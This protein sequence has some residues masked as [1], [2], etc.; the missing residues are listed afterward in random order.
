MK[1]ACIIRAYH[2][3]K[4]LALLLS[5]LRHP[6]VRVYLHIDRRKP[7]AP[8]T[9][10]LAEAGLRDIVLLPRYKSW[11]GSA[12]VVDAGLEGLAAGVADG[13]GYFVFMSGQDFPIQP[14]EDIVAFFEDAGSDSYL[15]YGPLSESRYRGQPW[16][17]RH[18]TEFYTYT[19]RGRRELCV[20]RGHDVS[21]MSWR[22]RTLNQLLRMRG[23]LKPPR[24]HPP[25]LR[26]FVGTAG[27]NMSRAAAAYVLR[28]VSEHP[29]YRRYHTYTLTPDE[30]FFHSILVGTD[31]ASQHQ[32]VNDN[33]RYMR[34]NGA[35]HPLT[36]TVDDLSTMIESGKL[37]ARKFDEGVDGLVLARLA[38]RVKA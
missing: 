34:W 17:G 35:P 31:F 1:V 6:Q 23:A 21:Y 3:P 4:Q 18:R 29:D 36:L 28:F 13:C 16:Y 12:G 19:V 20:P 10:A 11:W 38:E 27:W 5:V 9:R 33:L 7:L 32:V 8:F 2:L 25:Y 37:F 15:S 14:L 26:P 24:R 22:G 30:M